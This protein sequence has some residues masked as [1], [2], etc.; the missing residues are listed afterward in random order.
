MNVRV[1]RQ[2][3]PL[4]KDRDADDPEAEIENRAYYDRPRT[5]HAKAYLVGGERKAILFF[6]TQIAPI[7]H[8]SRASTR[9][10]TSRFSCRPD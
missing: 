5:L 8:C 2:S 3:E 7:R 4:P 9:A 10:E 6:G 1:P